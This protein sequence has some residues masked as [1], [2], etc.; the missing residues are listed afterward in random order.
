MGGLGPRPD[1]GGRGAGYTCPSWVTAMQG[2]GIYAAEFA[3]WGMGWM[4]GWMDENMAGDE[5]EGD[6]F[7]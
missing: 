6:S 2:Q 1:A 7:I 4:D 3:G 5:R